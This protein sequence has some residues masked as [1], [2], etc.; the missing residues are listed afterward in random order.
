[1]ILIPL[2]KDICSMTRLTLIDQTYINYHNR[3]NKFHMLDHLMPKEAL[4]LRII[5]LIMDVL[6]HKL[7]N[8]GGIRYIIM[9]FPY[10]DT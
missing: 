1:M 7:E 4:I 3:I 10:N 6:I 2:I 9:I 5:L 8:G